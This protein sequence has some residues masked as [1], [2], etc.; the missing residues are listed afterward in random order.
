MATRQG[1]PGMATDIRA[2]SGLLLAAMAAEGRSEIL[3]VYHI[4]RGYEHIELQLRGLGA[5]IERAT[6]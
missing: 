3:R 1:A 2:S 5:R 4:D 6:Q